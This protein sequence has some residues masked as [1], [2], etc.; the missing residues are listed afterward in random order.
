MDV[1]FADNTEV[2][3]D[4]DGRGTEHVVVLVRES[5]RRRN[6]NRISSVNAERIEILNDRVSLLN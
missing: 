5:L 4:V 3:D 6:D 2:A 1:T